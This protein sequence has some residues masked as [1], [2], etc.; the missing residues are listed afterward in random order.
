MCAVAICP[1]PKDASYHRD[2]IH[3]VQ[4]FIMASYTVYFEWR[5]FGKADIFRAFFMADIIIV[6]KLVVGRIFCI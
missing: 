1:S 2:A 5:S 4:I 3:Q 6:H